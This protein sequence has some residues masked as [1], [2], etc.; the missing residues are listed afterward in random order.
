MQDGGRAGG[1]KAADRDT[2]ETAS[3][4]LS[5]LQA[6]VDRV[7][8]AFPEGYWPPLAN[9]ARLTEEIGELARALNQRVG[10]KRIKAGETIG[11]LSLE[12]GDVLFTLSVLANQFEI[13]LT[14]A[15][16]RTLAKVQTRDLPSARESDAVSETDDGCTSKGSE[17]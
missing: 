15:M 12:M 11:D 8:L 10:A 6:E 1:G 4:A 3:M 7:I 2:P 13:D 5:S 14:D 9:L 16:V 17:T